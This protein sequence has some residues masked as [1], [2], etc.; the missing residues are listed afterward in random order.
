[1]RNTALTTPLINQN[2]ITVQILGICS[3]L[4]VTTAGCVAK[5][6]EI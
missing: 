4:A 2:P 5:V 1:M 3:A 6:V